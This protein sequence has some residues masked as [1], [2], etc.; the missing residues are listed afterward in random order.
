MSESLLKKEFNRRDVERVR[1]LVR[2]DYSSK[3]RTGVGY[4]TQKEDREEGEVWEESGKKW[5]IKNGIK[6]NVTKLDSARKHIHIPLLCP[7]CGKTMDTRLDSKMYRIHGFCFDCTLDMES[8]LRQ[9]GLFQD[10]EQ[11]MVKGNIAGFLEDLNQWMMEGQ[12]DSSG[13]ITENGEQEAWRVDEQE[14]R[15]KLQEN[16]KNYQNLL[17]EHLK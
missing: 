6:Q 4:E 3:T 10:Y 8:Q 12:V 17:K 1:N 13:Y 9:A 14:L 2:K 15:K 16:L 11:R 5:T 7:K